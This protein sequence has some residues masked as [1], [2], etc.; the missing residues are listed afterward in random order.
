MLRFLLIVALCLLG[1]LTAQALDSGN[2]LL[3]VNKNV[4]EGRELAR[5]YAQKRSVPDGRILELDLPAGDDIQF[6]TYESVVLPQVRQFLSEKKLAHDVT[7]AVTFYGV[8]LRIMSRIAS[9]ADIAELGELQGEIGRFVAQ[10]EPVVA[11]IE[12]LAK[13]ANSGFVPAAGQSV[14]QLAYRADLAART[15]SRHL[16]TVKDPEARDTLAE[17]VGHA[18]DPLVG[19]ANL[20]E[21]RM[22][23]IE[24]N[25]KATPAERAEALKIR[26]EL[27]ALRAKV[28]D[29]QAHRFDPKARAELRKLSR[30]EL[31]AFDYG[32]LLGGMISYFDGTD[33]QSSFDSELSL[34]WW[35]YY[36]RAKWLGNPLSHRFHGQA[37]L[38]LMT[39]R[40]DAPTVELARGIIDA[41]IAVEQ[42]GLAGKIVM[43]AGGN[44]QIDPKSPVYRSYDD[45]IKRCAELVRTK[46]KVAGDL[47]FD[48]KK[49]ILPAHSVDG[50]ALYCGWYA[51]RNYTP[52]CKFVPGA[53]GFHIGSYELVS[54]RDPGERGWCRGMLLD[55]IGAT[56]GP[57]A[58]P[59][60]SAFPEADEFFGLLLTGKLTLAEVYWKTSPLASWRITM[61]GDP[62]YT[63]YKVNPAIAPAD[64]PQS[65]QNALPKTK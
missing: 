22:A 30:E 57:E 29:L 44:L 31:G 28:D 36:T 32:R 19:R 11:K 50:V 17:L 58:E 39:M 23:E 27:L 25:A 64:L 33:S 55:G 15:L 20:A 60:L 4:P 5:H 62:L 48:E 40:I 41:S 46:S 37:P 14:D 1:P 12:A 61:I 47:V 56:L 21:R 45:T 9:P 16:A 65:L 24:A 53:I 6:S 42:K 49:E 2:L 8:P 35:N 52:T 63:P 7:C 51:V 3:I 13:R 18:V 59:F 26:T 38:A 43:D 54:L 10:T 34:I